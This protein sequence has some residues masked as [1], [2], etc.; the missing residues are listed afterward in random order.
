MA[1]VKSAIIA[2]FRKNDK[3]TGSVEVQIALLTDRIKTLTAHFKT[4]AKDFVSKRGL[5]VMVGKRRRYLSYLERSD[6]AKYRQ[7]IQ[8]LGLRK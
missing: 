3:D 7:L 8:R 4:H 6:E 5:L 1:Q 2:D